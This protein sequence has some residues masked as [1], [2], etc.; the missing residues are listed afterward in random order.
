MKGFAIP[1]NFHFIVLPRT[2]QI[3]SV[4]RSVYQLT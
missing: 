4:V 1:L 2:D 3:D